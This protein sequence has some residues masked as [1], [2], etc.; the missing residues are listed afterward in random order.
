[1]RFHRVIRHDVVLFDELPVASPSQHS[2]DLRLAFRK[3]SLCRQASAAA[4]KAPAFLGCLM[5]IGDHQGLH[6]LNAVYDAFETD[7]TQPNEAK[8]DEQEQQGREKRERS[9][10]ACGGNAVRRMTGTR[11]QHRPDRGIC[12]AACDHVHSIDLVASGHGNNDQHLKQSETLARR[13]KQHVACRSQR[14]EDR[15][16]RSQNA[17][18]DEQR[19]DLEQRVLLAALAPAQ[20]YPDACKQGDEPCDERVDG[21][22]GNAVE[23]QREARNQLEREQAQE[24]DVEGAH[25]RTRLA[26]HQVARVPHLGSLANHVA[27]QGVRQ[28]EHDAREGNPGR[29][30]RFKR[31]RGHRPLEH[32]CC[33]VRGAHAQ[34]N[35]SWVGKLAQR[36]R[37]GGAHPHASEYA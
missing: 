8:Y 7:A 13:S 31:H 19:G 34:C 21:N 25:E 36:Q 32:R 14:V 35:A 18:D 28:H 27:R 6:G 1:M 16:H 9:R 29:H 37:E 22:P 17:G 20:H 24:R 30:A 4:L 23:R 5:R 33:G 15:H 26:Q 10:I 3:P 12:L 2:H 11:P